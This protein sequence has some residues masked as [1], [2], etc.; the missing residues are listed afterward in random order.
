MR[1]A[2]DIGV[3]AV[4]VESSQAMRASLYFECAPEARSLRPKVQKSRIDGINWN[5]THTDRSCGANSL[6]SASHVA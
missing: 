3:G 4:F 1:L 6:P 5:V 2:V